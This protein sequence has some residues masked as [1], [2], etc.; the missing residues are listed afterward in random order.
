MACWDAWT[1]AR[2][3][4]AEG[5]FLE[6]SRNAHHFYYGQRSKELRWR[7]P[8]KISLNLPI[9]KSQPLEICH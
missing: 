7:R 9:Q 6:V 4:G 8:P 5:E 3:V 1:L 2:K